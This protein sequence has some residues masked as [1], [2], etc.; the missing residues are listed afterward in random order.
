M[1]KDRFRQS[2]EKTVSAQRTRNGVGTLAEKTLHAV[3][4]LYFDS[5]ES[6]HEVRVGAFVADIVNENGIIEIQTRSLDK[7]R[8]KLESFLAVAPVT[9]VYPVARV[10]WLM[11]I[12]EATGEITKRRKS[13]KIGTPCDAFFELYRI[14]PFLTHPNLHLC[15]VLLEME[16]YRRLNGWSAD[17][18]KG[19]SRYERIP[20]DITG[21]IHIETTAQYDGLLPADL[22]VR[23]TVKDFKTAARISPKSAQAALNVLR[24]VGAVRHIGKIGNQFLYEIAK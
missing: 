6:H 14:K 10:K 16:E 11:W 20:M 3:L 1:D 19:S 22:P 17:K 24:H 8:K 18:K 12:D 21:E 5:D 2:C 7:L 15:V 4:K 23:F 13:P 9:V